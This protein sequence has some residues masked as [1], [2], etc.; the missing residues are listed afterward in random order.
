[1]KDEK[2]PLA[3]TSEQVTIPKV[4][5]DEIF[6]LADRFKAL[7]EARDDLKE[8]L[9][10]ANKALEEA[11]YQLT[12]IMS[13]AECPNFTRS[14]KQFIMTTTTRWSAE[15][16]RKQELYDALKENGY[17]H[18]FTVNA[19]TL[20]SFVREQVDET[21]DEKGDTHVPEWLSGLVKSYDDIGIT[22]KKASTKKTN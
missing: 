19:Q 2:V 3:K 4:T 13:D 18:L 17:D 22:M 12:D 8:Q 1:M 10:A 21:V 5:M 11:E 15:A 6:T 9:A 20:G 14:G 16:E 7:R